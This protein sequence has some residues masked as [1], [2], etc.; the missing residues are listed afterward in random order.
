M[1]DKTEEIEKG[2]IEIDKLKV[3][4]DLFDAHIEKT[5]SDFVIERLADAVQSRIECELIELE[6]NVEY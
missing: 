4:S 3:Q 5:G 6:Y 2:L 1:A